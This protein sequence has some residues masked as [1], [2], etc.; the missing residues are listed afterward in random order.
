MMFPVSHETQVRL[1]TYED[2]LCKWQKTINLVSPATISNARLRHFDDSLQL[3]SFISADPHTLY[4][5]GSGAGFPGLVI[6]I[7]RPDLSVHLIESDQ[8]KCEFLRTVS[9]E[10]GANV[11][12]HC[13]RIE[14][15][16]QNL[17]PPDI[18]TARALKSLSEILT[19][20]APWILKNPALKLI[21]HK[22]KSIE[23]EVINAQ[24][25][26]LFDEI[27]TQSQ[28][29]PEGAIITLANIRNI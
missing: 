22:G 4:D 11:T 23:A 6:A 1:K 8:R 25:K 20:S 24:K 27:Q 21:L 13:E 17:A 29:D 15:L 28:T 12:I 5:L 9:R 14:K 18:I 10:T 16:T 3:L 19:L 26:W 7:T 2:I